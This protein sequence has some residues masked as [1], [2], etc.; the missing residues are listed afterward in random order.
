MPDGATCIGCPDME[1]IPDPD[2]DDWF[3]DDDVAVICRATSDNPKLD[4]KH[5]AD[6]SAF[7]KVTCACRPYNVKKET[8]IP[9]WCP[10]K[11]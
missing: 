3:N 6:R 8:T 4:S 10:R 1:I 7:K 5:P 2:P 11:K 9:D